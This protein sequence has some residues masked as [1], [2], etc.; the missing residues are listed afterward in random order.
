MAHSNLDPR[1]EQAQAAYRTGAF[2]HA[3]DLL[4]QVLAEDPAN[5]TAL[6][7]LL[8]ACNQMGDTQAPLPYFERARA[9]APD[10]GNILI[11]YV[12]ALL[13]NQEQQKAFELARDALERDPD[14]LALRLQVARG[15]MGIGE[16]EEARAHLWAAYELDPSAIDPLYFLARLG[17]KRD[18]EKI[19]AL[20][21]AAWAQRLTNPA[22]APRHLMLAFTRATI[23]EKLGRFDE[24]WDA[25]VA[26]NEIHRGLIPFDEEG[27]IGALNEQLQLFGNVAPP[28]M[29]ADVPGGNLI[30]IVSLPR[31]GSTLTEQILASHSRVKTIGERALVFDAF[32]IWNRSRTPAALEDARRAYCEGAHALLGTADDEDIVILDKSI[33][34]YIYLGFLRLLFP[35][36]KF[37]HVVRAPMDAGFSCYATAFGMNALKWCSDLGAIGRVFRRYQKLMKVWMRQDRGDLM[38]LS[39]EELTADPE[40]RVRALL[41]FCKLPWEPACLA[42]HENKRQVATASVAQVR[43]PI[44][45]TAQGRAAPF[46]AH[47]AVL[48]RVLGRAA[49]PDWYKKP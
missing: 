44:H 3:R 46:E 19:D 18:I 14:N 26:G 42:F 33:T 27:Y 17:D 38:T 37:V 36:A 11:N 13:G 16:T 30:F 34:N 48:R 45:K 5:L 4:T 32:Q 23:T 8:S 12:E 25:Y 40:T 35:R 20:S 15:W 22:D 28:P 9:A 49:D 24:A 6:V 1:I 7:D 41:D 2:A 21:A 29:S 47:L 10:D 39:Y 31:S 43:R